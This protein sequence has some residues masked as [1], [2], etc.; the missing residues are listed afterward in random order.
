MIAL[1]PVPEAF[2]NLEMNC[3]GKQVKCRRGALATKTADKI[4]LTHLLRTNDELAAGER[5][6]D[7]GALLK[8]NDDIIGGELVEVNDQ[9]QAEEASK[10]LKDLGSFDVIIADLPFVDSKPTSSPDRA[11]LDLDHRA[12]L[13]LFKMVSSNKELLK[14]NGCL[15][16]AFSTL[17][18]PSDVMRF[19]E[20]ITKNGLKI[21]QT[22]TFFE[23]D[24]GWVVYILMR[25]KEVGDRFWWDRLNAKG[26]EVS[27]APQ[28]TT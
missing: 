19:E 25:E 28:P 18:G 5:I 2:K 4:F 1:E 11:Y 10:N 17:G 16:T 8:S 15:L 27:A 24:V 7:G 14:K 9:G 13:T 23:S 12:H 22:F 6:P 21:V 3:S 26:V 20:M